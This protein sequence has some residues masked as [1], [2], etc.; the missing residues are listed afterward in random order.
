MK[1]WR[2]RV[3]REKEEGTGSQEKRGG[4]SRVPSQRICVGLNRGYQR[5]KLRRKRTDKLTRGAGSE[6][7]ILRN[8][9][10]PSESKS[11]VK[12]IQRKFGEAAADVH[13]YER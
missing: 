12:E 1:G 4:W 7:F 8:I 5:H 10:M 9:Y 2:V 6:I 3:D 13:R 11:T